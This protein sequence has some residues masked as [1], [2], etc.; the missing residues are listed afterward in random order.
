VS[1]ILFFVLRAQAAT[2]PALNATLARN[3]ASGAREEGELARK[4]DLLGSGVPARTSN[5]YA[6]IHT[7][8][9]EL[10]ELS[11]RIAQGSVFLLFKI[12]V[13]HNYP[14]GRTHLHYA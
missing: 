3:C 1:P 10:Q 11:V 14:E 5:M 9:V 7:L 13:I 4:D 6:A 2:Q 8:V 12:Q